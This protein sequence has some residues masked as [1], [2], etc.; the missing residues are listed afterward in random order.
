VSAG[1]TVTAPSSSTTSR[2]ANTTLHTT[3]TRR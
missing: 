1:F 3:T 2:P